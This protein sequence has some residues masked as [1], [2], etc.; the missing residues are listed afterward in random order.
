MHRGFHRA[1]L[2]RE[3]DGV[4]Q[5]IRHRRAEDEGIAAQQDR[6]GSGGVFQHD[7]GDFGQWARLV[8][9]AGDDGVEVEFFGFLET[10]SPFDG[11]EFQQAVD[12]SFATG[13]F[14]ADVFEEALS[15]F[16]GHIFVQQLRRAADGGKRT[17]H[18]V[19]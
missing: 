4:L 11:G 17:F 19:R 13:G 14:R 3:V 15:N 10:G 2:R 8:D 5:Q 7:T 6:S 18:F 1:A 12:E 9:R 16:N